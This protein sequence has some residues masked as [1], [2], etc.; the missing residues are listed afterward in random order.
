MRGFYAIL[1]VALVRARELDEIAVARCLLAAN[2]CALQLRAKDL[3]AREVLA[4]LRRLQPLC[5]R[6]GVPLVANDRADLAALAAC[7]AV[8]VGQDDIPY[9]LVAR[10]APGL[11]VGIS[12]HD[13]A[14]LD[15]ALAAR[16]MYV[17]YGPVFA[18]RTK[19]NPDPV[20]GV[21]GLREAAARAARAGIPL[22]AIGGITL[23]RCAELAEI[24]SACAIIGDVFSEPGGEAA[25]TER[26]G[27]IAAALGARPAGSAS[28]SAV[29]ARS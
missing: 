20:V 9:D 17:A 1:D 19:A 2:P 12:T 7:D 22:V 3:G 14:Q 25:I 8:H 28:R 13:V 15:R 5:Q 4:L 26:A 27:L 21:E 10:L 29:E 6:A 23:E 18:T 24:A 11:R 16:P